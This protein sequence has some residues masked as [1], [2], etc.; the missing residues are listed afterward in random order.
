VVD[1]PLLHPLQD[2]RA[3]LEAQ[4]LPCG[5]HLAAAAR[6]AR[7]VLSAEVRAVGD[8]LA[9]GRVLDRELLDG[10][11][12]HRLRHGHLGLHLLLDTCH[13]SFSGALLT[14]CQA[15]R[16]TSSVTT[17]SPSMR[18]TRCRSVV[19]R[20]NLLFFVTGAL[21]AL[22][23]VLAVRAG[24]DGR[25]AAGPAPAATT[26][27]TTQRQ[28]PI[29][30]S[31]KLR[32]ERTRRDRAARR[33]AGATGGGA[34]AVTARGTGRSPAGRGG[35]SS[36]PSRTTETTP[37]DPAGAPPADAGPEETPGAPG[38]GATATEP[39][40]GDAGTGSGDAPVDGGTSVTL[41]NPAT[42]DASVG[43]P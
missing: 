37:A 3:A 24:D 39:A 4:R 29:A 40:P 22:A 5:L 11:G 42:P 15:Y 7:D 12:A 38:D 41:P 33:G 23:A 17:A 35:G 19:L 2:A 8:D 36:G 25:T 13:A 1:H 10:R 26:P 14:V 43:Q 21:V 9:G 28:A 30:R 34:A 32:R 31:V 27:A 18:Q 20:R 16:L 6:H